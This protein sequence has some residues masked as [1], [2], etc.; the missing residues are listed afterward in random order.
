[1][2]KSEGPR[3]YQVSGGRVAVGWGGFRKGWSFFLEEGY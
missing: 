1:M 2:L 3:T